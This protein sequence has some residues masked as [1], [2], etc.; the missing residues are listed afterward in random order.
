MFIMIAAWR[1]TNPMASTEERMAQ[2]YSEAAVSI[3][4][5]S[6]TD[7]LA[8]GIGAITPLPAVRV[9]CLFAG[10]GVI[11]DYFFQITFFGACMVYS[12]RREAANRHCITLVKVIPHSQ[13]K[14]RLY[15]IFCAGGF[16]RDDPNVEEKTGETAVMAFFRDYYGPALMKPI[17]KV[18]AY[19]LFFVY[20][21]G[22]IYGCFQII[23]GLEL[24]TLAGEGSPTNKFFD[25][26]TEY[27]SKYGPSMYVVINETLD[28]S[29]PAVQS[30]LED[31]VQDFES[32]EYLEDEY[33]T[34]FW[35]SDYLAFLSTYPDLTDDMKRE[36]F[37]SILVDNFLEVPQF[38]RYRLDINFKAGSN[39]TIIETSRIILQGEGL[40][41]TY[42][43]VSMMNDARKRAKQ[44]N[45][46]LIAFSPRFFLYEQF[47]I[48]RPQTIQNVSIAVGCMFFVA[49]L[50]IPQIFCTVMVTAC[51]ISIQ[52]GIVGYMALWDI[53]LDG[54]SLINIIL[55]IG[56]SVDFSAHITY[57]FLAG[58]QQ[59]L[60][61]KN[62]LNLTPLER[63]AVLA[64]YSLG[65][66]VLQGALSTIIAITV[67]SM[68][69]SYIFQV[70]FKIM[71]MVMTFG[72]LHSLV[73]LP[74]MLCT[75]GR[76]LCVKPASVRQRDKS[77]EP[78]EQAR[79]QQ[80]HQGE[81]KVF[82]DDGSKLQIDL[83]FGGIVTVL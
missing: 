62:Q 9:F 3:T 6:I 21:A 70:F 80:G 15:K 72:M 79:E 34:E 40:L 49:L 75:I 29:D 76:C 61:R 73:F 11:F 36:Q 12:G 82:L 60:Q 43:Q 52:V 50:F 16:V 63:Q 53:T 28:Y 77:A 35:L 17:S 27:F 25:Y 39:R 19:L 20:L 47:K 55:C 81:G 38:E 71:L 65:Q 1:K 74:V 45:V 13:A 32:S 33:L 26:N 2:T 78:A 37:M 59:P 4:I 30:D 22:A 46:T 5:T 56:F 42:T 51:I 54:I 68:S 10:V 18:L 83:S 57:S 48:I 64:L 66:P 58:E 7:A 23:E 69:A 67:L 41:T 14:S 8:F 31:I 44:Q 24:K